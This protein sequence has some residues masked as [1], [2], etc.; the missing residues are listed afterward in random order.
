MQVNQ[1]IKI[2]VYEASNGKQH[3]SEWLDNLDKRFR[4]KI[5]KRLVRVLLGNFGDY[6]FLGDELYELRFSDGIRVYYAKINNAWFYC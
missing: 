2:I 1:E 3:F 5:F 4:V 6:K